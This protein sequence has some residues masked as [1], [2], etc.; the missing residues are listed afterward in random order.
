MGPD[1][2]K[3]AKIVATQADF[4]GSVA[5][6]LATG[7]MHWYELGNEPSL[8]FFFHGPPQDYVTEYVAIRD[9]I[10]AADPKAF[11]FSGGLAFAGMAGAQQRA[12]QIVKLM[13]VDKT[14]AWAYHGHGNGSKAERTWFTDMAGLVKQYG[15]EGKPYLET[16][17]GTTS[18]EPITWRMQ[19][20]T[21]VQKLT[22]AQSTHVIPAFLWFGFHPKWEW[23]ILQTEF[24]PSPPRW[25]SGR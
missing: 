25:R 13:P 20:R 15:K 10:K 14:D 2:D 7:P 11:V 22:Y 18:T 9:A 8:T 19:A 16:E 3:F 21:V 5:A 12:D 6:H 4:A 1:T 24:R 23:G 17:S